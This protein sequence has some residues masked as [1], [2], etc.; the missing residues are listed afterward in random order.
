MGRKIIFYA[1]SLIFIQSSVL[2]AANSNI[3]NFINYYL[4]AQLQ[5]AGADYGQFTPPAFAFDDNELDQAAVF[6]KLISLCFENS[7]SCVVTS[8][9]GDFH[10]LYVADEASYANL[11]AARIPNVPSLAVVR[12][13]ADTLARMQARANE[14]YNWGDDHEVDGKFFECGLSVVAC[15]GAIGGTV[16][17]WGAIITL[18]VCTGSAKYCADAARAANAYEAK[19]KDKANAAALGAGPRGGEGSRSG[20]PHGPA[21]NP[22]P[23]APP[24][25]IPTVTTTHGPTPGWSSGGGGIGPNPHHID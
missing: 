14:R 7:G 10:R 20:L 12:V 19:R 2:F 5:T 17:G 24:V 1:I 23:V 15:V 8:S 11:A 25:R 9:N 13:N 18:A 4:G 3:Q 21:F 6:G 22:G 16:S